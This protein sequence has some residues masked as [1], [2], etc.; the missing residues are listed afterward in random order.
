MG[1]RSIPMNANATSAHLF[2]ISPFGGGNGFANLFS[3][4]PST[5]ERIRRL[6]AM[7]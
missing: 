6:E 4:H 3:T 5:A 1:A 2:Q 7:A